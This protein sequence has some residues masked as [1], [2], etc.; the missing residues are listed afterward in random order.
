MHTIVSCGM[1]SIITGNVRSIGGMHTIVKSGMRS[2]TTGDV[3]SIASPN[4]D[5]VTLSAMVRPAFGLGR[6]GFVIDVTLFEIWI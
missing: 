1:T 4:V 3:R 6:K 5:G 2:I